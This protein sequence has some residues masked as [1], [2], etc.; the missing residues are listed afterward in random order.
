MSPHEL[1]LN[2][3]IYESNSKQIYCSPLDFRSRVLVLL[4]LGSV[5]R[6]IHHKVSARRQV[7]L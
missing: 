3:Y 1:Q 7:T 2:K 6:T 5:Q 4:P